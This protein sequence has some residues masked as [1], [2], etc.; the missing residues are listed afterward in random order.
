[1]EWRREGAQ[2]AGIELDRDDGHGGDGRAGELLELKRG[3]GEA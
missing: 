2:L 1:M 3:V